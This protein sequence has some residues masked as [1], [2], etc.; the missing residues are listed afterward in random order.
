MDEAR[1]LA[2]SLLDDDGRKEIAR[3]I[4]T[5][6][7]RVEPMMATIPEATAVGSIGSFMRGLEIF[8]RTDDSKPLAEIIHATVSLRRLGGFDWTAIVSMSH[9]YLPVIRKVFLRRIPDPMHALKAYD[10]VESVVVPFIARMLRELLR[11]PMG[12]GGPAAGADVGFGLMGVTEEMP[13]R[14]A[15]EFI[16]VEEVA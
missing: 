5:F 15:F 3:R 7:C 16:S 4:F 6:A 8:L 10:V 2:I 12:P 14:P 1:A 9:C 13:D 11:V